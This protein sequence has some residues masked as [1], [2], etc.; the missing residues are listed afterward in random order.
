[1]R[2]MVAL[3]F[4]LVMMSFLALD[5]A[6]VPKFVTYS[7]RLTDG[8][9][10]DKSALITLR[11]AIYDC[12][13]PAQAVCTYPCA[14]GVSPVYEGL[15]QNV[16]VVDGY[17]TLQLGMCDSVGIC[18][19][20]PAMATFPEDLPPLA[21][22]SVTLDEGQEV[23]PRQSLGS[24]PYAVKADNAD[25]LGSLKPLTAMKV[26]LG[27]GDQEGTPGYLSDEAF[28]A[29]IRKECPLGWERQDDSTV[30][31]NGFM[32]VKPN[33]GGRPDYMVKVGDFW[34]DRYESS[35]F[36]NSNCGGVQI[37]GGAS[38]IPEEIAGSQADQGSFPRNGHWLIPLYACSVPGET[39]SQT[40]TWFQAQQAC[41]LAGKRLCTNAEWQ[42]AVAGTPDPGAWPDTDYSD[43]CSGDAAGWQCNTCSGAVRVTGGAP[44]GDERCE[45]HF[46]AMDM[47]GN[48]LE[49]VDLWGQAGE[50]VV[51]FSAGSSSFPWPSG[52]GDDGLRNFN[53]TSQLG[54]GTWAPGGVA[55][56]LRGGHYGYHEAA[57]AFSI[58]MLHS[59]S[60]RSGGYGARCC[61]R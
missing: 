9:F 49:W 44:D 3:A 59:P 57:G 18:T 50:D 14:Q 26:A 30:R 42:M 13:C 40:I 47:I 17:F 20:D 45:S 22:L 37:L 4:F 43:G 25:R 23:L 56:A 55:A 58:W 5:A 19:A 1:M 27:F 28:A 12:E 39:P 31:A 7:G 46:G 21:W 34:I 24:V 35:I 61:K 29:Y 41:G 54:S 2:S 60:Y 48:V 33:P 51:G 53:G 6:A 38:G 15:F 8:S 36:P 10:E 32:C 52:Y 16:P 11:V